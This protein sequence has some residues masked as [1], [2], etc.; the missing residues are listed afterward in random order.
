MSNVTELKPT[1]KREFIPSGSG[2]AIME[3][4]RVVHFVTNEELGD[5]GV[6]IATAIV[7]NKRS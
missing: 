1:A 7:N 2:V 6:A 4:G 5:A 3:K